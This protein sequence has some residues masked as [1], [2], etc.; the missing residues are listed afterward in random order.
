[1]FVDLS[2]PTKKVVSETTLKQA[3]K[4]AKGKG[5]ALT[6]Q[7]VINIGAARVVD[8]ADGDS[9]TGFAVDVAGT[10]TVE[11]GAY[12]QK[13]V[14]ANSKS[15]RDEGKYAPISVDVTAGTNQVFDADQEAQSNI[16][17]AIDE[18]SILDTL[19]GGTGSIDWTLSDDTIIAV[20]QADLVEVKK[21]IVIR[22]AGL[23][24]AYSAAK[25]AS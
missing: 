14:I 7:D 10:W 17:G 13:Q 2:D 22:Y 18:F 9:R 23:H 1:M 5:V 4:I 19:N 16:Q 11:Y 8:N 6:D 3:K 25:T 15:A 21:Q 12:T 24:A 20:T